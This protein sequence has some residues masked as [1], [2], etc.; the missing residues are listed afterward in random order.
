[1]V[2]AILSHMA[3]DQ[4]QG[5]LESEATMRIYLTCYQILQVCQDSRAEGVLEK[6]HTI[7]QNQASKIQ[8]K[9]VQQMFLE[10]IPWHREIVENYG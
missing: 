8:N 9:V 3:D 4:I 1:M 6:A 5:H 2:D 10:N 7:L